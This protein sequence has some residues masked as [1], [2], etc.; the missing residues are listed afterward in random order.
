MFLVKDEVPGATY[1]VFTWE[2]PRR[3]GYRGEVVDDVSLDYDVEVVHRWP[4]GGPQP[5]ACLGQAPDNPRHYKVFKYIAERAAAGF[6]P[7]EGEAVVF[8]SWSEYA[9]LRLYPP[10]PEQTD[11][12]SWY[13]YLDRLDETARRRRAQTPAQ[14]SGK[15]RDEVATWLAKKHLIADSSIREVWYL[16]KEAPSDEIRLLELND[17]LAGDESK[18]EAIDFGLNVAG[19]HFRLLVADVTSD[20]LQQI[21]QDPSRLPPGWSLD[22]NRTW[23]RRGA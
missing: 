16:P 21:R 10:N 11:D 5:D 6:H 7:V 23:K 12:E 18:V 9:R 13:D 2:D 19:A 17:R 8:G 3:D 20:Q 1:L 15:D 4:D 14:P 22:E